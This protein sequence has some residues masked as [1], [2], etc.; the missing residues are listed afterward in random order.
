M[1]DRLNILLEKHCETIKGSV[2]ALGRLLADLSAGTSSDPIGEVEA[3]EALAHQ[4]K[5]SSGTAGFQE[6]S[7]AATALDDHLKL[8]CRGEPASVV[9]GM[10]EAMSLYQTLERITLN[11]TPSSSRLYHAA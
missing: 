8:L 6:V 1:Q 3:A 5:G 9:S 11:T 2:T 10:S 7:R 4:L